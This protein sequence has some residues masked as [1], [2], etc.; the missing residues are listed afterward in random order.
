[1]PG[2]V[3]DLFPWCWTGGWFKDWDDGDACRVAAPFLELARGRF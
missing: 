2:V 1:M 3:C